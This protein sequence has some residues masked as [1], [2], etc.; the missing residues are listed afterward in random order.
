MKEAQAVLWY[1]NIYIYLYGIIKQGRII[2]QTALINFEIRKIKEI[3]LVKIFVD[4]HLNI[5]SLKV[6]SYCSKFRLIYLLL[7]F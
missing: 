4:L 5:N 3:E 6:N 2:R 1:E 7:F